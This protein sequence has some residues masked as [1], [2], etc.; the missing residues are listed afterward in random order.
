MGSSVRRTFSHQFECKL[1]GARN[2][3]VSYR[4][5]VF[6]PKEGPTGHQ[7]PKQCGRMCIHEPELRFLLA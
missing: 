5:V 2:V 3:I 6:F 7:T 4:V 1:S